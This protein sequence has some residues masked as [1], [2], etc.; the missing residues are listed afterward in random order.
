MQGLQYAVWRS[1]ILCVLKGV[2]TQG[3]AINR[4][5]HFYNPKHDKMKLF[6]LVNVLLLTCSCFAQTKP[7][8]DD[9]K[10][11]IVFADTTNKWLQAKHAF[12]R[13]GFQVEDI[14]GDIVK[15][16][17][18]S[19]ANVGLVLA[20]GTISGNTITL[21]GYYGFKLANLTGLDIDPAKANTIRISYY[22]ASKTW[23]LLMNVANRLG[24]QITY[25][26]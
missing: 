10:I 26:N 25:G 17:P 11:T 1:C 18:R 4:L 2:V 5:R 21:T 3:G 12:I 6:L 20:T 19:F 22:K 8:K 14:P 15:T 7:K 9:T 13:E 24:S 23:K 16:Y